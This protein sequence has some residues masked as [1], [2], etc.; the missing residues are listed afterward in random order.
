MGMLILVQFFYFW[1][2]LEDN[3]LVIILALK[4]KWNERKWR[5]QIDMCD[6]GVIFNSVF[7]VRWDVAG[8]YL[9]T[10]L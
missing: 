2:M 9:I 3:T 8:C 10:I 6:D 7:K 5:I 1:G 4:M